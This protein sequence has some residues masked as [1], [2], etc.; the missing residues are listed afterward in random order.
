MSER[1]YLSWD[2]EI[3][4]VPSEGC[5]DWKSERPLGITCVGLATNVDG[6]IIT[7]VERATGDKMPP[8]QVDQ[9]C[10]TLLR[11]AANGYTI[12]GWNT[13]AF[14]FDILAEECGAAMRPR[15]KELALSDDHVDPMF[16][17]LCLKGYGVGLAAVWKGLGIEGKLDG[18]SGA[19][20]P[21]LWKRNGP[22]DRDKVCAYVAQDA[23][24]QLEAVL[25]VERR[26]H[27]A[28]YTKRGEGKKTT[29]RWYR[30]KSVPDALEIE[31]PDLSWMKDGAEQ[32]KRERFYD[33]ALR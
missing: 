14:D 9:I 6:E 3:A 30:W 21:K 11:A 27:F 19:E 31:E 23:R 29:L 2:I 22:G 18:M 24:I 17:F 32:W 5:A 4:K 15:I 16:H 10:E 13:L 1:R 8:D 12:T 7:K 28:W 25:A 26:G 20:A 33:W